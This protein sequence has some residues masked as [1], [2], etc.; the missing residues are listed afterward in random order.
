VNFNGSVAN[1]I[2]CTFVR[3]GTTVTVTLNSGTH[4]LVAGNRVYLNFASGVTDGVY[5]IN[6]VPN[7]SSFIVTSAAS[8]SAS[9]AVTVQGRQIRAGA[10]INYVSF[11]GTGN[12]IVN[13]AIPMPDA[14]Y[15]VISSASASISIDASPAPE[16]ASFVL[17]GSN[18]V[19]VNA[20]VFD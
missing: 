17:V 4:P 18:S 2:A 16:A 11:I 9:G 12:F 20:V 15:T 5:T 14:D 19:Y 8:G 7:T 13:F 1:D 10:N 6:S 3:V